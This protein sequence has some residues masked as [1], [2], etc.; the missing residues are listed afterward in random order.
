MVSPIWHTY[1]HRPIAIVALTADYLQ[2]QIAY[3]MLY[4]SSGIGVIGWQLVACHPSGISSCPSWID[5]FGA[6]DA[7]SVIDIYRWWNIWG[8]VLMT[9]SGGA[10]WTVGSTHVFMDAI[11]DIGWGIM[12]LAINIHLIIV[13]GPAVLLAC[14]WWQSWVGFWMACCVYWHLLVDSTP[15]K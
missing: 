15:N 13:F 14:S 12:P 10:M 6:V 4:L 8:S 1:N 7:V 5:R 11:R 9:S 3:G 2:F